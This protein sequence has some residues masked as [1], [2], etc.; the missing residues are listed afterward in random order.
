MR[1]LFLGELASGTSYRPIIWLDVINMTSQNPL[2]G[3]GLAN[4]MYYWKILG[5]MSMTALTAYQTTGN[6]L[7][8]SMIRVPSH[9][10][11][12][13]IFAQ[14]GLIGLVIFI[15]MIILAVRFG[16]RLTKEIP[17]GFLQAHVF[18]VLAGFIGMAVGSFWFADWLIPFVY[19]I[20]ISGF[21][22]SVYTWLLLGTLVSISFFSKGEINHGKSN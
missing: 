13:D 21:R 19:N 22:H 1:D 2:F 15:V 17:P 16:W 18:G 7:G 4:Y 12:V 10:M 20:T 3:L 6:L 8:F 14:T 11:Y 5:H 9:N